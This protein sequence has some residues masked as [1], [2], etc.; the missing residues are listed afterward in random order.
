MPFCGAYGSCGRG[1]AG[2]PPNECETADVVTGK[3]AESN[4]RSARRRDLERLKRLYDTFRSPGRLRVCDVLWGVRSRQLR[5]EFGALAEGLSAAI[6]LGD[7]PFAYWLARRIVAHDAFGVY[8]VR[9]DNSPDFDAFGVVDHYDWTMAELA[10]SEIPILRE[11]VEL[12]LDRLAGKRLESVELKAGA[13]AIALAVEGGEWEKAWS[14]AARLVL[15][16]DFRRV[17]LNGGDWS[18]TRLLRWRQ[19]RLPGLD[20][21]EESC[22][23]RVPVMQEERDTVRLTLTCMSSVVWRA[24]ECDYSV[25][26]RRLI[27]TK[28]RGRLVPTGVEGAILHRYAELFPLVK[29]EYLNRANIQ[30]GRTRV[31]DND[32][33]DDL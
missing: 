4:A 12:V 10:L 19:L 6:R 33:Q 14:I 20:S 21:A 31:G 18:E 3:S 7:A 1:T 29:A 8:R 22:R 5:G 30:D 23:I 26:F 24:F 16:E 25:A 13:S 2:R 17:P 32:G 15:R 28:L 11:G 9:P 27:V